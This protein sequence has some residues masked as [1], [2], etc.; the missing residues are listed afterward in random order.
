MNGTKIFN[1]DDDI[2]Q[3]D[4]SDED[5]V[6]E[7]PKII[8]PNKVVEIFNILVVQ[9]SHEV[10]DQNDVNVLRRLR[11]NAVFVIKKQKV[12]KQ[13]SQTNTCYRIS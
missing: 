11:E 9:C 2:E 4:E 1:A 5:C 13:F 10:V 6:S 8:K 7:T 12:Q 3:G